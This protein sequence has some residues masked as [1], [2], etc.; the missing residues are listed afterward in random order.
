MHSF[1]GIYVRCKSKAQCDR[2]AFYADSN[3]RPDFEDDVP[4]KEAELFEAFENEL[5]VD[6]VNRIDDRT[7]TL[8][9]DDAEGPDEFDF[10]ISSVALF[11]P[12]S[13]YYYFGTDGREDDSYYRYV[14]G[15]IVFLFYGA[16]I[17]GPKDG[18]NPDDF[19][20]DEEILNDPSAINSEHIPLEFAREV[21]A[22][23]E[24]EDVLAA[25]QLLAQR[26]DQR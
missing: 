14:D 10:F 6:E 1:G 19:P 12:D 15:E 8:W 16:S 13:L 23:E 24:T 26:M 2:L 21:A 17:Q 22:K 18:D 20:T 9:V 5:A 4:E 3:T 25:L 7:L 11:E